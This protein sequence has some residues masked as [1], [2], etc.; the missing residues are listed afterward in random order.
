VEEALATAEQL[1]AEARLA[2]KN[3][4]RELVIGAA[5]PAVS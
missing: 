4:T 2:G 1:L 3:R 5:S